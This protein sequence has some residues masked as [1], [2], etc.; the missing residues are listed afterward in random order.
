MARRWTITAALAALALLAPAAAAAKSY[1]VPE[2]AVDVRVRADGA[3]VVQ[4]RLTFAFDGVFRGAY[5]LL[6]VPLS[7][8]HRIDAVF[9]SEDGEDYRP[10]GGTT[11][12]VDDRPGTFGVVSEGGWARVVWHFAARDEER[13]FVVRYR[14]SGATI[15]YDDVADVFLQVWGDQWRVPVE[16]L[17]AT[18]HLPR[19]A[20]PAERALVRV[21]GHPAGA[22]GET[23]LTETGATLAARD[24]AAGQFVELRVT[25]PRSA[26]S[27]TDGATVRSGPG[28]PAITAEQAQDFA[29]SVYGPA[30]VEQVSGAAPPADGDGGG[31]SWSDAVL[32]VLLLPVLLL[33]RM[34]GFV[35][36]SAARNEDDDA[37]DGWGRFGGGGGS[38][39]GGSL[40]GRG[41]G[42]AGGGGGGAW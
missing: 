39:R 13:T 29:G 31:R 10:G 18:V 14:L 4:E 16:R 20:A 35:G 12:G 15:A 27:A 37:D 34:L 19:G 42:G 40:G 24:V 28:L 1:R 21:W 22:A 32:F 36:G 38:G 6:P 41:G 5:R 7:R 23:A 33:L 17:R 8:G 26:L 11:I 3:L 30:P 9:V 25:F 2:A